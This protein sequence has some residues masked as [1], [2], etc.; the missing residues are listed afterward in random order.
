MAP[1]MIDGKDRWITRW[2]F[3]IFFISPLPRYLGKIPIL[4]NIFQMGWNHQPDHFDE[5]YHL[6]SRW[7]NSHVLVHH[8]PLQLQNR[9]LFGVAIAIYFHPRCI[10]F[11]LLL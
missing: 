1:G 3:Q 11:I 6:E 10:F 4:T 5:A 2:W 9:H 7:R 8:G